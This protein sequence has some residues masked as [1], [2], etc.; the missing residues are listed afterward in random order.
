[1]NQQTKVKDLINW[2]RDY[3]ERR[4]NSQLMDERRSISPN[5]ILDFGSKGLLG[6]IAP[7]SNGGLG[8][9]YSN[10]F[11]VIEQVAGIDLNLSLLVTLNNVLGIY[12]ILRYGNKELQERYLN[13][14]AQGRSLA[15]FALTEPWAGSNPRGIKTKA[16]P[17]SNG[18]WLISGTKIWCGSA[19]WASV[20]NVFA[21]VFDEQGKSL[22]ISAFAI[23]ENAQGLKQGSEALTMG[24][25][26][27]IQNKIYFNQ[28]PVNSSQILGEIDSGFDVA[29]DA[30]QLGRLMIAAMCI[31]GMKRCVQLMFRY[32]DRRLIGT[33]KL[34]NKQLTLNRIAEV[35]ASIGAI[36]C[37]VKSVATQLDNNQSVPPE[38]YM[39]LKIIAPEFMWQA[40]DYLV[41]LLGGRGYIETNIA[42]QI[43]R[44]ARILRIFEGPTETMQNHLGL[45]VLYH[46]R[47]IYASIEQQFNAPEIREQL[48]PA[49][50]FCGSQ[51]RNKQLSGE[52][53]QQLIQTFSQQLGDL[54]AWAFLLASVQ[55]YNQIETNPELQR[56]EEW[57]RMHFKVKLANIKEQKL[58]PENLVN[59]AQI[60]NLVSHYTASIGNIEQ[61]LAGEEEHLDDYLGKEFRI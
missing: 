7:Q 49:V 36:E 27:M 5:I 57:T 59:V 33:D 12:P 11:Q 10:I 25:R 31:G 16:I 40:A 34:I 20:I 52:T 21:Y 24:M 41:Q 23:P 43:L 39:T 6:M 26:G 3:A 30:M 56:V 51:V 8:F 2:L 4:V 46:S 28:V 37:L 50:D 42:P 32:A 14:L 15:A 45:L 44:D 55:S 58:E 61:Q 35:T 53:K 47:K 18:G 19:Q 60:E 38:I 48:Q 9:S 22:G 1:M 29:Q 17:D 54:G 13:S